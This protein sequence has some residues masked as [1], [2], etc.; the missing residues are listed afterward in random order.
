MRHFDDFSGLCV[1]C[2]ENKS[3]RDI[4]CLL[5][6]YLVF[7]G[8]TVY[9]L[10]DTNDLNVCICVCVGDNV[11]VFIVVSSVTVS[12][13]AYVLSLLEGDLRRIRLN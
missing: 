7:L 2:P 1:I 5:P 10:D 8:I 3:S 6:I 9:C 4:L 13:C 12:V 11:C